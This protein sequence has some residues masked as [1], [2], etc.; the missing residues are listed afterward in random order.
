M[1][2]DRAEGL[3]AMGGQAEISLSLKLMEYMH[4]FE[5]LQLEGLYIGDLIYYK[6]KLFEISLWFLRFNLVVAPAI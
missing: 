5:S 3:S 1:R 4:I 2:P 6:I